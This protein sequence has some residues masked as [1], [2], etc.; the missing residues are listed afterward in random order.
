MMIKK[1]R[2]YKKLVDMR[3]GYKFPEGLV[4]PSEVLNG[5]YD[6]DNQIGPWSKWQGNLEA[7][8]MLIGQDWGTVNFFIESNGGPL[9]DSHTNRNLRELF[10][11]IGIDVGY[12][13]NPNSYAP[14]FF[15]NAIL[16]LKEG[17]MADSVKASWLRNDAETFLKPT[18]NI[19]QP[20]IIITLGKKAYDALA[21]IYKLKKSPLKTLVENN[22]IKLPDDKLLFAVYHCGGLGIASRNFELQ[23]KDWKRIKGYY[24]NK[25]GL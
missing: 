22:P 16:G 18:I 13:N 23:K 6:E 8:I 12:P 17:A 5:I 21:I 25:K 4:N 24:P 2:A 7:E 15:T 19:I 14:V 10:N 9:D 3:K 1:E 20:K 11:I